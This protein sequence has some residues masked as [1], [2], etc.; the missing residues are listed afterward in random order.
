MEAQKKFK[1]ECL[2]DQDAWELFLK[3]VGEETLES[4]PDIPELAKTVAKECSGLPLALITTGRA[5]S[6]K[7]T[8]E[9]WSYAIQMLRRSAYE[10]PGMEKE[11][12]RLLKF[13]YDSLSSDVLR[14]CLL[15]C[16]LF[17]ED[18]Q[19]SKIEL[20]GCWIG[21]G[22]LKEYEGINGVHNQ[23]YYII[24]VL[25][26]ACLLEEAGSDY[27]KLHDV[28]RDMTLWIA[29]EVE[30]ENFL[31]SAGIEL[32]EPPEVKQWEDKR[33]ISLMRNKIVILPI[34]PICPHLI[35]LFL[36][37]N[38]L[39]TIPSDFFD[40][41]PSLKVLNLSKN[42]SLSQL[43]SGISKLV[44]LQYL[45]LSET[46]IKELPHE[47]K[48]LKNLKCLNLEYMRYLHTI[49]RQLLCNFSGLKVLRMLDCGSANTVPEDSV[50]FGGSEILVE[51]LITLEHLNVLSVTLRSFYALRRL[52][53][54]QQ[55]KSCKY[56]LELRRCEDSR[57]WNILSIAD[58][59]YLDKLDFVYCTSL[60]ELKVD[61]AEVQTTRE[62]MVSTAFK[63]L[64]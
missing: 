41:M 44:S 14:S 37:I 23:G 56:A 31:V 43:P 36:G 62:L 12:F 15:Y 48:A 17:P 45:N 8:P 51:E 26:H 4:H 32:T 30:N 60:E 7:K 52:L 33:R 63:V 11:V 47:L 39:D 25:V 16:S 24:G 42:R 59:K 18:Y 38:M 58:L 9:E 22:F 54:C 46:F 49:P 64:P 34:T 2:A 40:F 5:M 61:Y 29:C 50:L 3:K 53:S 6:S 28:I 57:S 27:V 19:I 1:V 35:T 13:S 10:F 55:Y 21:E 20:I